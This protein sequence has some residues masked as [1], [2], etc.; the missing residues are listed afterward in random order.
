MLTLKILKSVWRPWLL[1]WESLTPKLP[2][3]YYGRDKLW[4]VGCLGSEPRLA[5]TQRYAS[6]IRRLGEA[7]APAE[8]GC[9]PCPVFASIPWHLPYNWGKSWKTSVRGC[10]CSWSCYRDSMWYDLPIWCLDSWCG[11]WQFVIGYHYMQVL[12]SLCT[13]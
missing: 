8:W 2:W 12:Q 5:E 9:G 3:T 1:S 10:P 4:L 11:S 6:I 13:N 7:A